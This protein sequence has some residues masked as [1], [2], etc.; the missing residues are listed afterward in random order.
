MRMSLE[1]RCFFGNKSVSAR[2]INGQITGSSA[3]VGYC[4]YC[5]HPGYLTKELRKQHNCIQKECRYYVP[6][7]KE[8][9]GDTEQV[10]TDK[11]MRFAQQAVSDIEDMRI[12]RVF[13]ES[14]VWVV[15]YITVFS[16]PIFSSIEQSLQK[17]A[18][19][20]VFM[21]REEYDFDRCVRLMLQ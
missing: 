5:E 16:T 9:T 13:R 19:A 6:K 20:P 10:L 1:T 12:L 3:C 21:E 7:P 14:N 17:I 11:L 18:G 15:K 8:Q 2:C 4:Q